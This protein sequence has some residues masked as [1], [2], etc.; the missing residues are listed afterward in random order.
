MIE[1]EDLRRVYLM[2]AVEVHALRGVSI[3]V[4]RG[5]FLGVT[6]ESG[7]GKSTLLHLVGILDRP[8]AGRVVIDG[9]DVN[10]LRADEQATFRLTR[11]GFVFQEYALVPEL[12]ALEN[13]ML[14][15]LACGVAGRDAEMRAGGI[16]ERIGL[17][18]RLDH[19][20][21]ELSG[22]EQQRVAIAR[23]LIND[24]GIILA[25]EPCANLDS[26]NSRLVMDLFADIN[27]ETGKT[28]LM[29][30]HEDWHRPYFDRIVRLRDGMVEVVEEGPAR[31][32]GLLRR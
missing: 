5:E 24:P 15:A 9:T 16:M 3:S 25:D 1:V 18:E 30:S 29:V 4:K 20:P 14:P 17:G 26:V 2:G 23:A 12:T 6:G 31:T 13:V 28:I 10:T 7:S 11:I 27:R 8:T 21:R 32:E 19:L 22:G